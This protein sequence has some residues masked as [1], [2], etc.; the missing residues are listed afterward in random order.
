[1]TLIDAELGRLVNLIDE[2][3][4]ADDTLVLFV[5]DHGDLNGAHGLWDKGPMMYEELLHIP[6]VVRWPGVV[7][8]GQSCDAMVSFIDLMP[9]LAEAAELPLPK[10][11]DGRSLM[12]FLKGQT[13]PDWPDDVYVQ[14]HGEGISLYSIRAVRSRRY[15][16]VYYPFD[17]DE[18][19]D[20]VVDP[21]EMHN[22]AHEPS[23]APILEEMR[24]RMARWMTRVG[25]VMLDWNVDVTRM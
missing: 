21:W 5:S 22:L 9:T 1:V 3:D 17:R 23:A 12:P 4:I 24:E 2:L 16:Y 13:I 10:P 8:A 6:L 20:E 11:V 19:Y 18:L 15:K 7:P 14:Y 25:D